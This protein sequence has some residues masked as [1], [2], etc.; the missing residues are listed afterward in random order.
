MVN[1]KPAKRKHVKIW[2][3][4]VKGWHVS[5]ETGHNECLLICVTLKVWNLKWEPARSYLSPKVW[6]SWSD[7]DNFQLCK[8]ASEQQ[9]WHT[10]WG[11]I[12]WWDI[13]WAV[14]S[15]PPRQLSVDQGH[16]SGLH[17]LLGHDS[18]HFTFF[19]LTV[20]MVSGTIPDVNADS[21]RVPQYDL[22]F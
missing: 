7:K 6:T 16:E 1:I 11:G 19:P 13:C 2:T 20:I 8:V 14:T 17:Q 5:P 12:C 15:F 21:D 4:W 3:S 9:K 22:A 18:I 10:H